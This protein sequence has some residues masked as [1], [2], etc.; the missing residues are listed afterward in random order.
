MTIFCYTVLMPQSPEERRKTFEAL[1]EKRQEMLREER[2]RQIE[3]ERTEAE[4]TTRQKE[5][6]LAEQA[7]VARKDDARE[8]WRQEQHTKHEEMLEAARKAEEER[9]RIEAKRAK[10]AEEDA[11]RTGRMRDIH[12]RAMAQ[13]TAARKLQALHIEEETLERIDDGLQRELR[14]T[15]RMLERTLEHL[16]QDRKKNIARLEDDEIRTSK[17]LA[18]KYA[19]R[20]KDAQAAGGPREASAILQLTTEHKRALLALK[21]RTEEGKMKIETEY[22]RLRDEAVRKAD[23]KKARLRADADR[24]IREAKTRRENEDKWID[25]HRGTK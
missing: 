18:D 16:V 2:E 17:S 22:A 11:E 19:D 6:S 5:A 25:A 23:E 8:E 15:D 9:L 20:K 13:K 21:E 24:R 3:R 12:E 7:A 10:E 1:A 14:E 4:R